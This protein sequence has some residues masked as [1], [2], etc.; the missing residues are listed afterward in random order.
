MLP[1]IIYHKIKIESI[2]G[3]DNVKFKRCSRNDL[4]L[5][6]AHKTL[7]MMTNIEHRTII[8]CK[9]D[10]T[11]FHEDELDI[12]Y[13][14]EIAHIRLSDMSVSLPPE[15]EEKIADELAKIWFTAIYDNGRYNTDIVYLSALDK[16]EVLR[17]ELRIKYGVPDSNPTNEKY[18]YRREIL[19]SEYE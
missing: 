15:E 18:D 7:V 9:D 5:Y 11:R 6:G 19:E 14:H 17:K 2:T 1:S 16:T 8:M 13:L 12:I 10:S 4:E 3:V